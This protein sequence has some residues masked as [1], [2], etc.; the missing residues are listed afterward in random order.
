MSLYVVYTLLPSSPSIPATSLSAKDLDLLLNRLELLLASGSSLV[1]SEDELS[2]QEPLRGDVPLGGDLL[3]NCWRRERGQRKLGGEA[4]AAKGGVGKDEERAA[5]G[6]RGVQRTRGRQR[7]TER[8]VV[9]EVGSKPLGL[10]G[11]PDVL[12]E[13]AV[14]VA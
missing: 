2:G 4:L 8:V 10:E 7:L 14:S 9:L 1:L 13:N 5:E 6:K 3:V 12:R 11:G